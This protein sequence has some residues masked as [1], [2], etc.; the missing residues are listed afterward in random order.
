MLFYFCKLDLMSHRW[1]KVMAIKN[2]TANKIPTITFDLNIL[3]LRLWS[4]I[5]LSGR[6]NKQRD[7]KP[8]L[9]L[10]F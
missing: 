2:V 5:A 9:Y 1:P 6:P 7:T 4:V 10:N 3:K 8:G